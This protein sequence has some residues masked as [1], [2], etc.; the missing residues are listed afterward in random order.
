MPG[1]GGPRHAG[2]EAGSVTPQLHQVSLGQG[3]FSLQKIEPGE[4]LVDAP[5][6]P[7]LL[8]LLLLPLP[9]IERAEPE[10]RP[11]VVRLQGERPLIAPFGLYGLI[12]P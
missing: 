5:A 8:G 7:C 1:L 4:L 12:G 10:E 6:P 11:L 3:E 9:Q 2:D